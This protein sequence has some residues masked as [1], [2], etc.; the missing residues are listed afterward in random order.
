MFQ[1][2]ARGRHDNDANR[3]DVADD[4][5]AQE[6]LGSRVIREDIHIAKDIA[7]EDSDSNKDQ[8]SDIN[9]YNWIWLSLRASSLAWT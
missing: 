5:P 1:I 6:G 2:G 7:D 3:V 4:L 8:V 9:N